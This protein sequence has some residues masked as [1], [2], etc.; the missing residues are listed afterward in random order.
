VTNIGSILT[1][2]IKISKLP[3]SGFIRPLAESV[4][5]GTMIGINRWVSALYQMTK[6][7]DCRMNGEKFAVIGDVFHLSWGQ[8]AR[9]E[10]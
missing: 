3:W 10:T 6:M 7:F 4:Y 1:Y 9:K 5:D 8:F 2:K